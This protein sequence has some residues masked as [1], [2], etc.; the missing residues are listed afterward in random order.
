MEQS[1]PQSGRI[2]GITAKGLVGELA[3]FMLKDTPTN[4]DWCE[5]LACCLIGTIAGAV[6]EG[7]EREMRN[8]FGKLRPNIFTIYIGAS[9]L[10]FK[11]VPLKSA[12][13][14]LL[15]KVTDMYNQ[16]A[17]VENGI[18]KEEFDT[19]LFGC[20]KAT[21]KE[22]ATPEWKKEKAFLDRVA[23]DMVNFEA[24]ESFTSEGLT[25]WLTKHACGMVASDEFTNM[26]KGANS[27]DYMSNVM[28]TLSR[29]YDGEIEKKSTISRGIEDVK[30]IHVCFASATTPYIL[31]LMDEKFF[32][33][34]TGNRILWIIDDSLEK[35][36]PNEQEKFYEFFWG[37]E[38][39]IQ[40]DNDFN[41]LATKLAGIKNL[42]KGQ[43]LLNFGAAVELNKF[44]IAMYNQ[45]VDLFLEDI[46]NKD[47]SFIAGL[48]QNAMKLALIHCI[49]R[50]A[51][52]ANAGNYE[53]MME[54]IEEDAEWAI[55]KVERHMMYYKKL[56]ELSTNV[57]EGTTKT[58]RSDQERVIAKIVEQESRGKRLTTNIL[59]QQTGWL[60]D[61][62]QK[63][64]DT[65]TLNGA[66][67][68]IQETIN[69]K[70]V[71]YYTVKK[72]TNPN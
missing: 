6:P 42:P 66:V 2:A 58:Y 14:P 55:H 1:K 50:Y 17:C 53:S 10:G 4:P 7:E 69:G 11:T 8:A 23:K 63:I 49:G 45:A 24:P 48:A 41:E 31:S 16:K 3:R 44:R 64:L 71:I 40:H 27:K 20:L 19:R 57:R 38:K 15:N 51:L 36:D 37:V 52:D 54:I 9:R 22:K 60:K 25:T 32:W 26:F 43:V 72:K 34:G 5:N 70:V 61:D 65:M 13:R 12:V 47:S 46:M 18:T 56:W 21:G 35:I 39:A 67:E 29:L 28:E 68:L 33:Q 59:R 62:C 30:N